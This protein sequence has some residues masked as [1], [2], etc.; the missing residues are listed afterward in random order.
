VITC[1]HVDDSRY[2]Q[3]LI[4]TKSYM[5]PVSYKYFDW[6]GIEHALD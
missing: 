3:Q 4:E 6:F 1:E 2:W 5:D